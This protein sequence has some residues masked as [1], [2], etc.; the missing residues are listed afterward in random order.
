MLVSIL[1]FLLWDGGS[2]ETWKDSL[3]QAGT[4]SELL[5]SK[6]PFLTHYRVLPLPLWT[7]QKFMF[8]ALQFMWNAEIYKTK[9]HAI[10]YL[11]KHHDW[12]VLLEN[13]LYLATAHPMNRT[14]QVALVVKNLPTNAGDRREVGSIP[15]LGQSP[16]GRHGN[17]LQYSRLEN[18]MERGA[19]WATVHGVIKSRTQLKHAHTSMNTTY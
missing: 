17:P 19:W 1:P 15:G 12:K 14:S 7:T 8:S 6:W 3:N 2:P 5:E 9:F 13:G 11:M 16:G 10:S 4:E 18:P